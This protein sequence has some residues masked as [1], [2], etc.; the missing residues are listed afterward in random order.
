MKL[1]QF[2]QRSPSGNLQFKKHDGKGAFSLHLCRQWVGRALMDSAKCS[3]YAPTGQKPRKPS[4]L[5]SPL[6]PKKP[7][8][9][10][11]LKKNKT[12]KAQRFTFNNHRNFMVMDPLGCSYF[13]YWMGQDLALLPLAGKERGNK[14]VHV[15][16]W[17]PWL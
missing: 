8:Q 7:R 13:S 5:K 9:L 10:I 2:S 14:V 15:V 12:E 11:H 6:S 4:C 1:V 3:R 17:R 16:A